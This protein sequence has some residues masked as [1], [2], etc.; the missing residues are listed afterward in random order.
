M[1]FDFI[2]A[3]VTACL[4]LIASMLPTSLMA[5]APSNTR[6]LIVGDS[7]MQAV[8]RSLERDFAGE[9]GIEATSFTAIGSGLARMDL[10][11][12]HGQIEQRVSSYRPTHAIIM[13]GANDN[14]AMRING[15][16][17]RMS[18]QEWTSEYSRRVGRVMDIMIDGGVRN[19]YWIE[20]PDMRDNRL[21]RD[22]QAINDIFRMEADSRPQVQFKNV[23]HIL[24]RS[25]G[26]YSPYIIQDNGMPLDIRAG[27]G[28]HL[29][30][31]GADFLSKHLVPIVLGRR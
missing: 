11:D 27:D 12:W 28:I 26:S 29:N 20:L 23:R 2:Y 21:Q 18:S 15:N 5:Q 1:R 7:I 13:M 10:F 9:N 14:Q 3:P 4:L 25:P 31:Q 30:R 22:V 19:I 24:S 6:I 17:V 16:T 8:A